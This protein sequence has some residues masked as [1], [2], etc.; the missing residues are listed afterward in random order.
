VG[1]PLAPQSAISAV[2]CTVRAAGATGK[3]SFLL[4]LDQ[5]S[6]KLNSPTDLSG[7]PAAPVSSIKELTLKGLG[8][9]AVF[10]AVDVTGRAFLGRFAEASLTFSP[11][12]AVC[13]IHDGLFWAVPGQFL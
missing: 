12:D 2:E 13:R 5:I 8:G 3:V 4:P 7:F 6:R 9:T 10:S 1:I 11:G